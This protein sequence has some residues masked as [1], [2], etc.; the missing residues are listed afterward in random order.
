MAEK[1]IGPMTEKM[2]RKGTTGSLRAIAAKSGLLKGKG[3]TLT[4]QDLSILAA[5]AKRTNDTKL[6]RKVVAAKNMIGAAKK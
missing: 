1:W 2:K 4:S 3:D 6:L 5:R